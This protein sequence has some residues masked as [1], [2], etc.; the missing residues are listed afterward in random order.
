MTKIR[1]ALVTG[2]TRGIGRGIVERLA[3]IGYSVV[4]S[5]RDPAAAKAVTKSTAA[6]SGRAFFLAANLRDAESVQ[7]LVA[8]SITELGSLDVVVHS[9]GIYPEHPLGNMTLADWHEVMDTNLTSALMLAKA[10]VEYLAESQSGR[11]VL[12]SSITGPRTG[13]S[14]L[15]H[16]GASKGGLEGLMRALAVE[17]APKGITVNSVAPGTILTDSLTELYDQ[18]GMTESVISIIPAGRLGLPADIAAAVEFLASPDSG[19]ITGQSLIVDGGQML[20]EVQGSS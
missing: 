2:G 4:F 6:H 15:A 3:A 5:G 11:I 18:P 16:Y 19:F 17:L 14:G 10:S 13:I 7:T 20:P 1:T 9:A 12:I 8:T